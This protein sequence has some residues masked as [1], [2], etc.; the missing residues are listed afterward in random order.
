MLLSY[1]PIANMAL[2]QLGES[3]KIAG[4]DED[5]KPAR[6]IKSAWEG[7]RQ[8]VL[9]EAHW[10][11]AIRT[12]ELTARPADPTWPILLGRTPFPMPSDLVSLMEIV[13]P[14][15]DLES[16]EYSIENG[17]SGQELLAACSGPIT[18]RY[19]RDG[20]DLEDPA[21]WSRGFVEA[22][23]WQLAWQ[24]SDALGADK[25]RKDRALAAA[26]RA[27][28]KAKRLNNRLKP[29]KAHETTPW[30]RARK[31]GIYRPTSATGTP[32]P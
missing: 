13:D 6:A 30:T 20:K 10:G 17:P 24:I 8:F 21:R 7:T 11:F 27:L 15:L 18:I 12:V 31:A 22:F 9:S 14:D 25:G 5:S 29:S 19:V 26:D 16:D 28:K 1:V 2:G 32:H 4:P 23:T 3:S